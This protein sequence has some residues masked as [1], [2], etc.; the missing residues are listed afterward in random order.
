MQFWDITPDITHL[1][2]Q[3]DV[4]HL[5]RALKHKDLNVQWQAAEALASLGKEHMDVLLNALDTRNKDIRLGVV[6][7]LGEIRDPRGVDPL[8]SVLHETSNELRLQAALALGEI[9][10][11]RAIKPMENLLQDEDKYVRYGASLALQKLGYAPD[12]PV[13]NAFLF[14][15]QQDWKRLQDM[16][17]DAIPALTTALSDRDAKVRNRAVEILGHIGGKEALS[18][19][20][21]ALRDEDDQVRWKAVLASPDC[22]LSLHYIPRGLRKRPRKRKDPRAAAILN[23]ILPGMGYTYLGKWWGLLIFQADV[24]LTLFIFMVTKEVIAS[25]I[26]LPAY[27][28][29]AI[30]AAMMATKMP[31]L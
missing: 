25:A 8:L 21:R 9:G 1:K 30:H 14:L 20:Y 27:L 19:V 29:L 2:E 26:L 17:T 5:I 11:T 23:F 16:G 22:G 31:E 24:T 7:V 12:T 13:D 3:Q 4:I 6:E 28:I 18:P 15:G 10:D